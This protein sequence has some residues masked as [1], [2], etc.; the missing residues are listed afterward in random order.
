[1]RPIVHST[2]HYVQIT[3]SSVITVSRNS[4]TL[5]TAVE[6]TVANLG[7]EVEE[8]AIVKAVYVELWAEAE[9]NS[10]FYTLIISKDPSGLGQISF[11]DITNLFAYPNKKNILYT[12]QALTANDGIANPIPLLKGWIKIPKSKQRFGLG[13]KLRLTI[14]SRGANTINYCGFATYKEYT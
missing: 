9:S 3:L 2:K 1:M 7:Q 5:V 13:D 12:S 6:S 14:A 8:G 10:G 11:A 4:E